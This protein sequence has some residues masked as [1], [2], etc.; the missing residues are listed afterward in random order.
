[1]SALRLGI[2]DPLIAAPPTAETFTRV[3][4]LGAL[5]AR[6]ESFW[7][8]DHLNALFPR[9][10]R[11]PKYSDAAKIARW[12]DRRPCGR[13]AGPRCPLPGAGEYR[14]DAAPPPQGIGLASGVLAGG[15]STEEA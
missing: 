11:S 2:M 10:L 14:H 6:V 5:E 1:M 9:S 15:Q 8:P 7:V 12:R 3:S 13:M 4:Y